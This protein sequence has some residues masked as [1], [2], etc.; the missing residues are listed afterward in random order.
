VKVVTLVVALLQAATA[1][2]QLNRTAARSTAVPAA[3]A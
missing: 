2:A 3:R 1:P